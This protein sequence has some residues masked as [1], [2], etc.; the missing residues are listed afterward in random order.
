MPHIVMEY[1]T[2]L[3]RKTAIGELLSEVHTAVRNAGLF[4]PEAIKSRAVAFDEYVIGDN[5]SE[6]DFVHVTLA[7]FS[8]RGPEQRQNLSKAI[9]AV[10]Q[11]KLPEAA[12]LTV[13]VREIEKESYAKYGG[14]PQEGKA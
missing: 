1:S 7:I 13:E 3:Q 12:S 8:G 5:G 2:G 14:R 11:R 4:A 10:L 9:L 6:G